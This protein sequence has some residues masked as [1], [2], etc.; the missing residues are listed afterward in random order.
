M[1]RLLEVDLSTALYYDYRF[2]N[3]PKISW[4]LLPLTTTP[5]VGVY[6][7]GAHEIIILTRVLEAISWYRRGNLNC[8][9]EVIS[10]RSLQTDHFLTPARLRDHAYPIAK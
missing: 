4:P 3:Q 1:T 6:E 2:A 8:F 9:G 7:Y 10:P 5:L